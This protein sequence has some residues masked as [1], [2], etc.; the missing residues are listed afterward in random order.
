MEAESTFCSVLQNGIETY[1]EPLRSVVSESIHTTLF[2]NLKEVRV[3]AMQN[4]RT[5][6]FYNSSCGMY[7][8]VQLCQISTKVESQLKER[9]L[10]YEEGDTKEATPYFITHVADIYHSE[11]QSC[12]YIYANS[13]AYGFFISPFLWRKAKV[14]YHKSKSCY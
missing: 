8:Y 4:I 12:T 9:R 14:L 1:L 2:C 3:Q 5:C 11:V 13:L 10:P 7:N 6:V